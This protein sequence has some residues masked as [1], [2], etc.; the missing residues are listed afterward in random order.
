M[1][2]LRAIRRRIAS[3]TNIQQVTNA[4]RMVATAKFRRAQDDILSARPYAYKF[5]TLLRH[6]ASQMEEQVHPLLENRQVKQVCIIVVTADRGLCGSFNHNI[7]RE[8][9]SH[10]ENNYSDAGVDLI[11]VGKKG[12]DFFRF[13]GDSIIAEH[14]NIFRALDYQYAV[15]IASHIATLYKEKVVDRVDVVYN[16]FQSAILQKVLIEQ[17]LPITPE[18]PEGDELFIDYLY[19]PTPEEIWE[20]VVPHHMNTQIWRI[21]LDSNAAEQAARM[22]AMENAT[23]NAKELIDE[24]VLERNRVRQAMITKEISEIVSGAEALAGARG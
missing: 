22:T 10:I 1:A 23:E 15:G 16:N 4:M 14:I 8:T 18:E 19:E 9:I 2:T 5:G 12:R 6:L 7:I 21:L 20:T 3:I 13:R 17:I 24:L 11:C